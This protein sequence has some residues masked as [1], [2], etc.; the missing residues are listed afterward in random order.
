VNFVEEFAAH[1]PAR[2][3]FGSFLGVPFSE[4]PPIQQATDDAMRGPMEGRGEA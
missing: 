4:L 1:L 3:F 2:V